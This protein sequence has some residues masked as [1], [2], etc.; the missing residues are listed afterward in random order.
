MT[1][2]YFATYTGTEQSI[3]LRRDGDTLTFHGFTPDYETGKAK[4]AALNLEFVCTELETSLN[5]INF[6]DGPTP[7]QIAACRENIAELEAILW[8]LDFENRH[9]ERQAEAAKRTEALA[10]LAITHEDMDALK[11][12]MAERAAALA[13]NE[14][15]STHAA[16]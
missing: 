2:P 12:V 16:D 5:V 3:V 6:Y 1:T 9:A 13:E 14:A 7:E 8:N 11:Q 10:V 4:A 15:A